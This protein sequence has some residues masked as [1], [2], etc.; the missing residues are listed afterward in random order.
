[1]INL[2][3]CVY[4]SDKHL[5][6]ARFSILTALHYLESAAD[7][8]RIVVYTTQPRIFSSFPVTIEPL[9][10]A[11]VKSWRGEIDFQFRT[12]IMAMIT[13]MDRYPGSTMLLDSDT[14]FA[15]S[16]RG[17]LGLLKPGVS[18]MD[19]FDG[20]IFHVPA[21]IDFAHDLKRAFPN[22]T[23][24]LPGGDE[25]QVSEADSEMWV[26]GIVGLHLQDRKLLDR[27]LQVCDAI[28]P[29]FPH[30][31]VEQF[32]F[33]EVLRQNTRLIPARPTINHYWGRWV[34]PYYRLGR[35]EFFHAQINAVFKDNPDG[36][37]KQA[38]QSL[39]KIGIRP[40]RRPMYY[41]MMTGTRKL[42]RSMLG[43]R[44]TL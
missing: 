29:H 13:V 18:I 36:D 24:P 42:W 44:R 4:D 35:R 37:Y 9:D 20:R 40:F 41:R 2:I 1:M 6:E 25:F 31:F 32:S 34:D 28:Y 39:R 23:I 38:L 17:L 10:Q 5:R 21:H 3:Y 43:R 15:K 7:E 11:I 22:L 26:A 33:T 16:P 19:R 30:T 8:Y 14:Y 12:K 27:I